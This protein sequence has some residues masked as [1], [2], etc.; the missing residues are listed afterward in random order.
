[1]ADRAT[2]SHVRLKG[3]AETI[4]GLRYQLI[5]IRCVSCGDLVGVTEY[6]NLG[7]SLAKIEKRLD[8]IEQSL[9]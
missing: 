3:S 7:A 5:V 4:S 8:A 2:C 6:L 1:M 9:P